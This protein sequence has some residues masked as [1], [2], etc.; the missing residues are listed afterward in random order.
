MLKGVDRLGEQELPTLTAGHD[1]GGA[2]RNA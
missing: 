1:A 2:L